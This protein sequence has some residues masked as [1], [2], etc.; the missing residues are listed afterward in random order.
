[1]WGENENIDHLSL[2]GHALMLYHG[3]CFRALFELGARGK[4]WTI[5]GEFN[6]SEENCNAYYVVH[7]R[8]R[9]GLQDVA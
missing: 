1:M 8:V 9:D 3:A 6:P 7:A 2:L 5:W 4:L